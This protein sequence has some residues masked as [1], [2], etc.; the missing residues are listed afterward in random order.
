[1]QATGTKFKFKGI[2][3][4]SRHLVSRRGWFLL[5]ENLLEWKWQLHKDRAG[6]GTF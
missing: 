4:L 6:N 1:M 5:S 2:E 3:F